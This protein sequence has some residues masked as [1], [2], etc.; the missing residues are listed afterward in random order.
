LRLEKA[1]QITENSFATLHAIEI[2]IAWL[3]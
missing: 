3:Q 2:M 1:S